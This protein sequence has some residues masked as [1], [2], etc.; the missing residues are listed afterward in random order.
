V[1]CDMGNSMCA[2]HRNG[3]FGRDSLRADTYAR[4]D[5]NIPSPQ[6]MS[7]IPATGSETIRERRLPEMEEARDD[8]GPHSK[9]VPG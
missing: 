2:H 9:A 6:A 3:R 1:R 5:Q 7:A 4:T 8:H